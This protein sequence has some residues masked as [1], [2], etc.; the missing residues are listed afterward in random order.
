MVKIS[1][2]Y[3]R[4]FTKMWDRVNNLRW[5]E[6]TKYLCRVQ[7][8][9][10]IATQPRVYARGLKHPDPRP[11]LVVKIGRQLYIRDGHHRATKAL[12]AGRKTILA[13]VAEQD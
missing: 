5:V 7:L 4:A 1:F 3:V 11:I 2:P 10:L 8:S 9:E 6:S 12:N 13:W